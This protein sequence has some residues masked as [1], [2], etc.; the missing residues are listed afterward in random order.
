MEKTIRF[1]I[2]SQVATIETI[3]RGI[4][5]KIYV[6]L[7]LLS[8]EASQQVPGFKPIE[9]PTSSLME[10]GMHESNKLQK[11]YQIYRNVR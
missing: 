2:D 8:A 4:I 11:I 3:L 6:R 10:L 9:A 5:F 1:L 7:K